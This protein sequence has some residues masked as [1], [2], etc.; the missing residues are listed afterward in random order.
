MLS[1][2]YQPLTNTYECGVV[3]DCTML[4]GM[5]L[6]LNAVVV[7][8]EVYRK[9]NNKAEEYE[10]KQIQESAPSSPALGN[11]L[12]AHPTQKVR[13]SISPSV[14][15]SGCQSVSQP[16][17]QVKFRGLFLSSVKKEKVN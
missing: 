14:I 15:H 5:V 6:L 10:D 1:F 7:G 2:S 8:V 12:A 9:W 13:L 4:V 16:V 3:D 11:F 17:R